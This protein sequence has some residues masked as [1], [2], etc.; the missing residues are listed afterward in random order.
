MATD[1]NLGPC[2]ICGDLDNP[3]LEHI[4][5]QALL[6]RMGVEPATTADHP[7][8][9]SL[10]NDCNTATSK[11][12]NNTDLLDLI[13]TGAPVSQNTL[14]ALAFWIVWITLLLGVKRGG[15]VWP[16]EDAR[17]RLQ[18]RFSDRSGGGVPKGTRVYA[19]LVNEDETSTLSAQYSI[20]LR[21][22]PRV[23]LDH[24]NFP[25]GYRPSGAKTA[26][27]VL[28][29]GNL[30]VMVLGPTWSSGPDHISLID[31]A[32]ADI[33][34]TPIW[35]S[36]NPEITLT[37]HTVA[38]K[39]VWNLFVC[40]PFTTRN[41]ELLPAALRALESAVSYLDPSTET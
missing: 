24:A 22:D 30:V 7:F 28:R 12:H 18:S 21:N 29:V 16:I 26:A 20:L 23:I 32:A 40:T 1:A 36:T 39:E 31:K 35:P 25:T 4:I 19:A 34:L 27:A 9:T 2:V 13:E 15:D 38:L 5:P 3:T 14:R 8:T 11:L 33:G 6:L 37:P 41:N 10:C 17:Q